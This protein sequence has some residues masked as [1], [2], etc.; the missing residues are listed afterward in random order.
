MAY[1]V[2]NNNLD[3]ESL[4]FGLIHNKSSIYNSHSFIPRIFSYFLESI[5]CMSSTKCIKCNQIRRSVA[6]W[7]PLRRRP[8]T[9]FARS[10]ESRATKGPLLH[11]TSTILVIWDFERRLHIILNSYDITWLNINISKNNIRLAI[12]SQENP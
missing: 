1:S 10:Y 8:C 4:W 3:Q 2:S 6:A 5:I 7:E 11:S 9:G 12:R